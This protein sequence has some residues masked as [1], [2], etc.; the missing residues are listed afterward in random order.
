MAHQRFDSAPKECTAERI[1]LR[2]VHVIDVLI[3][4]FGGDTSN[5]TRTQCKYPVFDI[6]I[7]KL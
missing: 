2:S 5:F 1:T 6:K 3:P 4:S 7:T